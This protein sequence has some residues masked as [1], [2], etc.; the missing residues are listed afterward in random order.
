[1]YKVIRFFTDLHDN[2]YAYGVGDT[3]PRQGVIATEERIAEL[4]GSNNKQGFPLIE[5]VKVAPAKKS[6]K[7]ANKN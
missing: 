1:M 3:Y 4:L 2:D 5:L 7:K 6:T